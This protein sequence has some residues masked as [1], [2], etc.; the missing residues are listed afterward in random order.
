MKDGWS[1]HNFLKSIEYLIDANQQ[2]TQTPW[3]SRQQLCQHFQQRYKADPEAIAYRFTRHPKG[4]QYL[5]VKS[6]RFAIYRTPQPR[7]YY[8]AS[9]QNDVPDRLKSG[10]PKPKR[11]PKGG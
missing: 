4:L 9:R 2:N 10:R 6:D 8:V 1:K 11:Q 5:L 7:E 3:I